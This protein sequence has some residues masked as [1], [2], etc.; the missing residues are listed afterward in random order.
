MKFV[1]VLSKSIM[2]HFISLDFGGWKSC[3]RTQP[4]VLS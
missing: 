1:N 4:F 2:R 3:L